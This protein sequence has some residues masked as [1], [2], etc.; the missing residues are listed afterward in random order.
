M[1]YL[2]IATWI[3]DGELFTIH[4]KWTFLNDIVDASIVDME[5]M[6]DYMLDEGKKNHLPS[7]ILIVKNEWI[8]KQYN[9]RQIRDLA[10]Q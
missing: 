5:E 9:A 6:C 2:I 1:E 7:Q 4:R 3:V 8:C 10:H